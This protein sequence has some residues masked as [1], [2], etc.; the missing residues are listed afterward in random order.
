MSWTKTL[1]YAGIGATVF[2]AAPV[3]AASEEGGSLPQL[4]V[5]TFPT[6]IFWLAVTFLILY[7]L[8]SKVAAPRIGEVLEERHARITNDLEKAEKLKEEIEG[9]KNEYENA[10]AEA[11][12]NAHAVLVS[13][14][15]EISASNATAEAAAGEKAAKQSQEAEDRIAK[16]KQD[17]IANIHSVAADVAGEAVEKL[18]GVK[19]DDAALSGAVESVAGGRS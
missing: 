3:L 10:L 1:S 19:V 16:A 4:D 12:A 2:A 14:Q 8:V 13:G 6:Q 15:S 18:I 9:V 17:A 7:I 11:R 5:S